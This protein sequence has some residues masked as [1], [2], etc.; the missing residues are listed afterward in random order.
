MVQ[1]YV[2]Y[3]LDLQHIKNYSNP[4]LLQM[5]SKMLQYNIKITKMHKHLIYLQLLN[6]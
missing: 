5:D 2:T 6:C 3:L 4:L 1:N